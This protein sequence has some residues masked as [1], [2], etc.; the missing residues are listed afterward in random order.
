MVEI[1]E[2]PPDI[3]LYNPIVV[4]GRRRHWLAQQ[5][6]PA[7]PTPKLGSGCAANCNVG[8]NAQSS[9]VHVRLPTL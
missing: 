9:V 1:I 5:G 6:W 4:P 2:Q 8:K 3:E 7:T